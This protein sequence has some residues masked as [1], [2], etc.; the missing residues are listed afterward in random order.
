MKVQKATRSHVVTVRMEPRLRYLAEIAARKQRRTLSSFI[1]WLVQEGIERVALDG[2]RTVAQAGNSLWDPDEVDRFIKLAKS[3]PDLLSYEEQ[4]VWKLVNRTPAF[5]V[6][7]AD[8]GTYLDHGLVKEYW[9]LLF[10]VARGEG[11]AT[12][13]P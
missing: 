7:D 2:R 9:E 5:T 13:L 12:D 4:M 3:Y 11:P 8:T 10:R 1:E 6:H